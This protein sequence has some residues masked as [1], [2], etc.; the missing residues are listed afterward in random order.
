MNS[1]IAD[2]INNVNNIE[3]IDFSLPFKVKRIFGDKEIRDINN[4]HYVDTGLMWDE[5]YGLEEYPKESDAF[6][7]YDKH[8]K[9]W[10]YT[11]LGQILVVINFNLMY[12]FWMEYK[13]WLSKNDRF[14]TM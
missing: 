12:N 7:E 8:P 6:R 14:G 1:S 13:N 5:V 4:V 2:Y 10:L 3:D 9:T 11:N